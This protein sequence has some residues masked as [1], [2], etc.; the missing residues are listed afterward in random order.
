[1]ARALSYRVVDALREGRLAPVLARCEPEDMHAN[2]NVHGQEASVHE[3]GYWATLQT[4][5]FANNWR[6]LGRSDRF[7]RR[8]VKTGNRRS[9]ISRRTALGLCTHDVTDLNGAARQDAGGHA[10]VPAHRSIAPWA[11]GLFHART[12]LARANQFQQRTTDKQSGILQS[13]K[14]DARDH[15][16]S[17]ET[18]RVDT[19]DAGQHSDD[20]KMLGLDECHLTCRQFRLAALA[21]SIVDQSDACEG[22]G[23]CD[24]TSN[25]ARRSPHDD[26]LKPSLDLGWLVQVTDGLHRT[27]MRLHPGSVHYPSEKHE[28]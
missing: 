13:Q 19:R 26:G 1:M 18:N 17:S 15:Q 28:R 20:S 5:K 14:I 25:V 3:G 4:F 23:A 11:D 16:I 2:L 24:G 12:G 22:H 9:E 7:E 27:M 6:P 21:K 8:V 10:A